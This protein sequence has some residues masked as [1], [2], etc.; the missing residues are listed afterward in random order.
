M[1]FILLYSFL[2]LANY[3]FCQFNF[4]SQNIDLQSN[5]NPHKDSVLN[6]AIAYSGCWGWS[7]EKKNKEYAIVCSV[8]GTYFVDVTNPKQPKV[9][10]Y[11]KSKYHSM[12]REAKTY[13]NYCYIVSEAANGLQ[14]IDLSYLPD[15]VKIVNNNNLNYL[16]SSHTIWVDGNK[17]YCSS[18]RLNSS[19]NSGVGLGVFSLTNPEQ[20]VFLRGTK[21][22]LNYISPH[23]SFSRHDTIFASSNGIQVI[24]Y[25]S[26]QNKFLPLGSYS[27]YPQ[28]GY[29]HSSSLTQ[30]GKYLVFC[31]EVP[32]GLPIN[33]VDV[34]N[35]ENIQPCSTFNPCEYTTPH[36]PYVLGNNIAIVSCYEDGVYIYDISNP[37]KVSEVGF[38]DTY[39]QEGCYEEFYN[40]SYNGNWGAYPYLPSKT[41][42]AL[43]RTNGLF[44][45]DA[46]NAYSSKANT[47]TP[48][49]QTYTECAIV[50]TIP[51]S[52]YVVIKAK[53]Q[54]NVVISLSSIDGK[55]LFKQNF[56][57]NVTEKINTSLLQTGTYILSVR[58]DECSMIKKILITHFD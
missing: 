12:W 45:L 50:Y 26:L 11:V 27:G 8:N 15:S 6:Y 49:Q 3:S 55:F 17:L 30:N 4:R 54:N 29:S 5:I 58:G 57:E 2:C 7:Q 35:F 53:K 38:F 52:E 18:L 14:I 37:Y 13:K 47:E 34:S 46:T 36:N 39:P 41:L 28:Q 1:N 31:D 43:D 33:I 23:D 42:L 51:A 16:Y 56:N 24:F 10:D 9:C 19:Y 40:G 25:D 32:S 20:P 22:D 44:C 21:T 48:S